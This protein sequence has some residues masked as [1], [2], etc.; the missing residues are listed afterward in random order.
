MVTEIIVIVLLQA[1]TVLEPQGDS[2]WAE[3]ATVSV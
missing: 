2:A 1:M 3:E